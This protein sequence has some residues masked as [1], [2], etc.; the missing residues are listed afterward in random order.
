MAAYLAGQVP[1][2][3]VEPVGIGDALPLAP[4]F[5]SDSELDY[6]PAPLEETYNQAWAVYPEFLKEIMESSGA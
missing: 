4:I 1:V 2:A 6:V 3:Y 5:L